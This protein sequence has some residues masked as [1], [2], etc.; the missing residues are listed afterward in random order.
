MPC[1]W[2][3]DVSV[4]A[5]YYGRA[6]STTRTRRAA[7]WGD[8]TA[9]AW[10]LPVRRVGGRC[11][12]VALRGAG[13]NEPVLPR[14]FGVVVDTP[15][16]H[17]RRTFPLVASARYLEVPRSVHRVALGSVHRRA[18]DQP[19]YM[20]PAPA[21]GPSLIPGVAGRWYHCAPGSF[22]DCWLQGHRSAG[23]DKERA[24]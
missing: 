5:G 12:A 8:K 16:L 23:Y 24:T 22:S 7:E 3:G 11:R 2:E 15:S 10:G 9:R 18:F 1:R 17:A 6:K 13:R 21:A 14:S 19:I 20:R 4:P